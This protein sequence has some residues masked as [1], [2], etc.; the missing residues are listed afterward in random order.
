M[1][2][3]DNAW[4]TITLNTP[5]EYDGTRN[6]AIIVDDNTGS[7]K[8]NTTFLTFNASNQAIRIFSDNTNYNATS[9]S[10][11]SGTVESSKNQIRVLIER[12]SVCEAPTDLVASEVDPNSALLTWTENGNST[13]W[14]VSYKRSDENQFTNIEVSE[15]HYRLTGL[16]PNTAYTVT[17]SA[18]CADDETVTSDPYN[19]STLQ[20]PCYAPNNLTA[21]EVG[22][23]T[24]T[25]TWTESGEA[26]E[27]VLQYGTDANFTNGTYTQVTVNGTSTKELTG[28]TSGVQYYARVKAVCDEDNESEW[29]N[30]CTFMPVCPKP[31]G[32]AASDVTATTATLT[33]TENGEATD[34]VLQYGTDNSFAANTYTEMS[35]EGMPTVELAELTAETQYYARVKAVC[36]EYNASEWSNVVDFYPTAYVVIGSGTGTNSR[37]RAQPG[38][39]HGEH[40]EE[41]IHGCE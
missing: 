12:G 16:Q 38:H 1:S 14:M 13:S 25:L 18:V 40:G 27:W 26:G 34:W 7:Y 37:V 24:A 33:W 9:L 2:F 19:F 3:A 41:R 8:S 29:S 36:D 28:L 32:L 23:N 21:S 35:V 10:S 17:V 15:N 30:V 5:F 39:L 22:S 20:A 6:V 11:Y 4:T 31:T